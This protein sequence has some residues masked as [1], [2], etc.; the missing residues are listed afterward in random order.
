MDEEEQVDISPARFGKAIR[1]GFSEVYDRFG[2][3]IAASLIWAVI[4]AVPLG[5]GWEL[6]RRNPSKPWIVLI[7][8]IVAV[9]IG[10]P[11]LAG[12]FRM[13][14]KVV[15]HDDP[16]LGD[17]LTGARELFLASLSLAL[18]DIVVISMLVIDAMFFM[19]MFGPLKGKENLVFFLA[20]ILFIYLLVAWLMTVLYQL[21]VLASQKPMCQRE[22]AA[23]AIRKSLILAAHNPGFTI[24]FFVVIL[25]FGILCAVSVF[26]ML[27]LFAGTV[28][29]LLTHALRELYIRYKVVEEAPETVED[30]G[31]K[32][33]E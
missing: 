16:G 2:L 26:G 30:K 23:A 1:K 4:I 15:Y 13:A 27:I 33:K 12:V 18:I 7:G 19:G 9:F 17:I 20:G 32:L 11:V 14:Y 21:P 3:V 24:G 10:S 8:M 29:M 31:W 25:G 5:L 6:W 22:G 28:S